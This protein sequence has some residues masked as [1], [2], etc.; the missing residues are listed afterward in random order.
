VHSP[1]RPSAYST[2]ATGPATPGHIAGMGIAYVV[3]LTAFYVDCADRRIMPTLAGRA[4]S[5][6]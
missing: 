1:R 3:M 5:Q 2:A 4:C 6:G